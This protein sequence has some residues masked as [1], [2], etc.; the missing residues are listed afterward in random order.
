MHAER[1]FLETDAKGNVCNVP[2]L[3]PNRRVEAIFLVLDPSDA[4][5]GAT[6]HRA[7]HPDLAGCATIHGD[8]FDSAPAGQWNLPA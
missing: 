8:I 6:P 7:P 5:Q 3:P 4:N 1:L 2:R